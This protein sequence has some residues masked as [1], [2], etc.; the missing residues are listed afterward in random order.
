MTKDSHR[1]RPTTQT[2]LI[3]HDGKTHLGL[4]VQ[5]GKRRLITDAAGRLLKRL[6]AKPRRRRPDETQG[7][8]F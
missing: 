4:D 2:V 1:Q 3:V 8:L 7:E 5:I 6:D